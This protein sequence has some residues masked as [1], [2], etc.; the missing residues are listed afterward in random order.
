MKLPP[1]SQVGIVVPDLKKGVDYYRR[2]LGIKTWCRTRVTGVECRYLG[3]PI[4]IGYNIAVGYSG[5][6]Q[7]ELLEVDCPEENIYTG[8]DGKPA[9]GFHHLGYAAK[10]IERD[11]EVFNS[12][13]IRILQEG[14]I[15]FGRAGITRF[16]YF[17]TVESAGF[18]L[19][20]IETRAFGIN[21]G[22]PEWLVK[23]GRFTGDTESI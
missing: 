22:M 11:M 10:N 20:A 21:L 2:L 6:N 19:E 15:R 16:A 7:V 12:A 4:D 5:K 3:K 8:T 9:S 1:V 18:I 23:T 14:T 17:D 13:G